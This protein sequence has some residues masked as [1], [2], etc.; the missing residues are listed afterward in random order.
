MACLHK[1]STQLESNI[2]QKCS[3]VYSSTWTL[4]W[5]SVRMVNEIPQLTHFKCVCQNMSDTLVML[6]FKCINSYIWTTYAAGIDG[7]FTLFI[8]S[9]TTSLYAIGNV[10]LMQAKKNCI[11]GMNCNVDSN[12]GVTFPA[13]SY[14]PHPPC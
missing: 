1:K 12:S 9:E 10:Q 6:T 8:T 11:G 5:L 13:F 7:C 2:I 14:P 3:L 4:Y